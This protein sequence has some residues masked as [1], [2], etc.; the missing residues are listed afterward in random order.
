MAQEMTE[1][2][3]TSARLLIAYNLEIDLRLLYVLLQE[4]TLFSCL[5]LRFSRFYLWGL[6]PSLFSD[7][8]WTDQI[9]TITNPGG[10]SCTT[11]DSNPPV[12]SGICVPG[13][14]L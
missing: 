8:T 9:H 11:I 3:T 6:F 2:R 1:A 12:L 13:I 4:E 10:A 7:T 14:C 5:L